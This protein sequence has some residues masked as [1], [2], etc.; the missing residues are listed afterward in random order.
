M[1]AEP[2]QDLSIFLFYAALSLFFNRRGLIPPQKKMT[3]Q[4]M[5]PSTAAPPVAE[6]RTER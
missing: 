6:N 4:K 5:A 1:Y 2:F 3:T